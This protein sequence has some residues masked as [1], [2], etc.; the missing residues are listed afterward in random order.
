MDFGSS[1]LNF[2]PVW[3]QPN[4]QLLAKIGSLACICP[5][6]KR[7]KT[8]KPADQDA[9]FVGP[10]RRTRYIKTVIDCPGTGPIVT[11]WPS[12]YFKIER[13]GNFTESDFNAKWAPSLVAFL[14]PCAI[15]QNLAWMESW[16][17]RHAG[18]LSSQGPCVELIIFACIQKGQSAP[19]EKRV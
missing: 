18:S 12:D 9:G 8:P 16:P 7:G 6:W 13:L 14:W 10:L 1:C 2:R 4:L 15:C 19:K 11:F 5:G 17:T 3:S